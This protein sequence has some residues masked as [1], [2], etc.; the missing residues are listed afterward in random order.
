MKMSH[1]IGR[2]VQHPPP[3]RGVGGE[4]SEMKFCQV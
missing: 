1:A 3:L 2:M 4:Q